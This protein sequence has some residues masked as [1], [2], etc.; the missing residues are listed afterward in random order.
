L[1]QSQF[2]VPEADETGTTF[3][4][5]ATIKARHAARICGLPAIADDSGLA[6]D[7][8]GGAPGV[9]S[10]LY[11][12]KGA[13]D[14]AN[15][16]KLLDDL[17][18]TPDGQRSARFICVM[19]FMRDADDPTPL[20]SQGVWEGE[21]LREAVGGNGFGYDPVFYAPTHG[22]SSAELPPEVKNQISHRALAL[23][24]LTER[25]RVWPK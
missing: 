19:V 8:L 14:L 20:I 3:I 24:A 15:T 1:P 22:C 5:N 7:A 25:L 18:D 10:A 6:V 12:G 2:A 21:I 13:G 9:I 4:E 23:R 17:R 11:A 16:Q